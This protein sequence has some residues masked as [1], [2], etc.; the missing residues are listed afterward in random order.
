ML[1]TVTHQSNALAAELATELAAQLAV[2]LAAELAAELAV[3][4][5]TELATELAAELATELAAELA[6]ALT[7]GV[8]A[9]G[10]GPGRGLVLRVVARGAAAQTLDELLQGQRGLGRRVAALAAAAARR[11]HA[12]RLPL[13]PRTRRAA[14]A[15]RLPHHLPAHRPHLGAGGQPLGRAA[16]AAE[17]Q[18]PQQGSGQGQPGQQQ[19]PPRQAEEDHHLPGR[20]YLR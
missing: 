14:A 10:G 3:E 8:L 7:V 4:L 12:A 16:G 13:L 2:E 11:V 15:A 5:A 18:V 20:G 17:Q 9:L 19:A 1:T 6:P